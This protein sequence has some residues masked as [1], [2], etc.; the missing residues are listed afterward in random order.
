MSCIRATSASSHP[1]TLARACSESGY[2]HRRW[3]PFSSRMNHSITPS[4]RIVAPTYWASSPVESMRTGSLRRSSQE[5]ANIPGASGMPPHGASTSARGWEPRSMASR[6]AAALARGAGSVI[7]RTEFVMNQ[8]TASFQRSSYRLWT[9]KTARSGPPPTSRVISAIA[10]SAKVR[11]E[12]PSARASAENAAEEW[13]SKTSRTTTRSRCAVDSPRGSG[14]RGMKPPPASRI[15]RH[16]ELTRSG[17][18]PGS[19]RARVCS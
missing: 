19:D 3:R 7:S 16:R 5:I 8:P 12:T 1:P 11:V 17:G 6:T 14:K 18:G 2:R 10:E 4:V 15:S 9:G 13:T